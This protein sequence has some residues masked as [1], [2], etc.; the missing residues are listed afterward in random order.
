MKLRN[1]SG[2]DLDVPDLR[3]IVAAGEVIEVTDDTQASGMAAQDGVWAMVATPPPTAPPV[4]Q[5]ATA[6]EE[7]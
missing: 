5:V 4:E 3:R 1:V 6:A 2:I 7:G